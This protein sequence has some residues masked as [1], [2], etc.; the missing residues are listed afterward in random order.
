K[1]VP[2]VKKKKVGPPDSVFASYKEWKEYQED[3]KKDKEGK[4]KVKETIVKEDELVDEEL[5]DSLIG[6]E[7]GHDT[8]L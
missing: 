6:D 2:D 8:A 1:E 7:S 3:K 5:L 4:D